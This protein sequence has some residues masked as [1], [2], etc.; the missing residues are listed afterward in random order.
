MKR[1]FTLAVAGYLVSAACAGMQA[2]GKSVKRDVLYGP[3]PLEVVE[4][5]LRLTD[6]G[7]GDIVY[8]LGS[9]DGRIVVAA[10]KRGARCVGI[11]IDPRR[12]RE[13]REKAR[14]ENVTERV[15]FLQENLFNADISSATVVTLFLNREVNLRLLPKLLAE[16][17]PGT[18]I[19]SHKYP[20]G[21]WEPDKSV[22]VGAHAVRYWAVPANLTGRWQ[23]VLPGQ[24]DERFVM[25]LRQQFQRVEGTVE[26]ADGVMPVREAEL[27]GDLVRFFTYRDRNGARET[28]FFTG[29][30]SGDG[31]EG[32]MDTRG[33]NGGRQRP[34]QSRRDPS[35]I[36]R[37]YTQ[38]NEN[39]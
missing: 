8:D 27:N 38:E 29:R 39:Q 13:G 9:G 3:T 10:A 28:L 18:R 4:E 26:T 25:H 19:V 24:K 2:A 23:W 36:L 21:A 22:Q 15:Q 1:L 37:L 7:E 31:I 16:L 5:M 12:V 20:L 14:R 35:S 6:I 32:V 30:V 17:K 11:D 34:W 33:E